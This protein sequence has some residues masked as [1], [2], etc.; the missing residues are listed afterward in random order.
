MK[1]AL[2][3]GINIDLVLRSQGDNT[4]FVTTSVSL[5]Q[6][7]ADGFIVPPEVDELGL[8]PRIDQVPV[9]QVPAAPP[10]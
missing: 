10:G 4:Q 8:S 6:V 9:P 5:P 3:T 1:W 2:E 7:F